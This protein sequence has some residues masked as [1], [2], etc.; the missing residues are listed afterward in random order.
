MAKKPSVTSRPSQAALRR[1]AKR[2]GFLATK[3]PHAFDGHPAALI[4]AFAEQGITGPWNAFMN[5]QA[6][7][8]D[9][10]SRPFLVPEMPPM[11]AQNQEAD[12]EEE[13]KEEAH[14]A[15][16]EAEE[17]KLRMAEEKHK[18]SMRVMEDKAKMAKKTAQARK[19]A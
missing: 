4:Q 19:S 10:D 16:M 2:L 3:G 5:E 17:D 12:G 14:Q 7:V 13:R 15:K 9:M 11:Q 18:L 1:E 8:L 6:K